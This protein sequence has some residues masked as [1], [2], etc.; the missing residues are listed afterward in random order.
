MVAAHT[1]R[2]TVV[3][4]LRME[5]RPDA[6]DALATEQPLELLV[7]GLDSGAG[8]HCPVWL[9]RFTPEQSRREA[10]FVLHCPLAGSHAYALQSVVPPSTLTAVCASAQCAIDA[11]V[12]SVPQVVPFWQ[13]EDVAQDVLQ[14]V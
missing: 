9:Q 13:S 6:I 11:H 2:R 4:T 3:S 10:H 5:K 8:T 12:W 14:L 1:R 7:G